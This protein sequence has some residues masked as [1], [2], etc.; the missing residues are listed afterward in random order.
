MSGPSLLLVDDDPA[1]LEAMSGMVALRLPVVRI[2]AFTSP[3]EALVH[4][5]TEEVDTIVT[6]LA[7]SSM[8]WSCCAGQKPSGPPSR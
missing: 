5:E 3:R 2:Y 1:L 8:D 7:M 6:D 4:L